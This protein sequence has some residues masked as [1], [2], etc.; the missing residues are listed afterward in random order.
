MDVIFYDILYMSFAFA[1]ALPR[2]SLMYTQL[3]DSACLAIEA[4]LAQA[5]TYDYARICRT[6]LLCLLHH[7]G[8]AL[9]STSSTWVKELTPQ[10]VDAM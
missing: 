1:H 7:C 5:C 9:M 8:C 10:G 3:W 4:C 6:A 2:P